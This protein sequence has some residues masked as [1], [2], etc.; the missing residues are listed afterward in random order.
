[1]IAWGSIGSDAGGRLCDDVR[2]GDEESY[3]WLLSTH[4]RLESDGVGVEIYDNAYSLDTENTR[5]TASSIYVT[6]SRVVVGPSEDD[7]STQSRLH[8]WNGKDPGP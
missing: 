5:S 6:I 8:Y 1:M 2:R 4:Y 7:W 3:H